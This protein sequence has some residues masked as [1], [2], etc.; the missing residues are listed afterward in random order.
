MLGI[1]LIVICAAL[2]ATDALFRMPLSRTMDPGTIV[3][4]EHIIGVLA[5]L[6]LFLARTGELKKLKASGWLAIAFIGIMGSALGT[7]F[8]TTSFRFVNPSVTILLQKMQPIFAVLGARMLLNEKPRSD[9]YSW[10][11]VAIVA[12][13]MISLPER[14]LSLTPGASGNMGGALL[15]LMA[16]GCWGLSTVCGKFVTGKVSFPVTAFLRLAFGLGGITLLLAVS[17]MSATAPTQLDSHDLRSILYMALVPGVIALYLYYAGLKRIKASNAAFAELVFPAAAVL[18]NWKFLGQALTMTQLTGMG[19]L[20]TA[21]FFI[22][23]G[24]R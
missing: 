22:S 5:T 8:F 14:S 21:V 12:A 20:L 16:A 2:W 10:G 24:M 18:I 7:F 4:L 15:A 11:I 19:L 9:F 17:L 3:F 23:K 13:A 6:P 1:F